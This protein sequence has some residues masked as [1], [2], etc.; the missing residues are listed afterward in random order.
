MFVFS[1]SPATDAVTFR[2]SRISA[3]LRAEGWIFQLIRPTEFSPGFLSGRFKPTRSTWR[4]GE[5]DIWR[6]DQSGKED[7]W[8]ETAY[9]GNGRRLK[10]VG[11]A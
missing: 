1:H 4:A 3:F 11:R 6:I 2:K 10:R 7:T 9:L 5:S 8:S